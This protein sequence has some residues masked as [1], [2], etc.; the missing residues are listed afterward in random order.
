MT[1]VLDCS[2]TMSWVF[3]DEDDPPEVAEEMIA[4]FHDP[5]LSRKVLGLEDDE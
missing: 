5:V 1:F 4:A 2:I 3:P